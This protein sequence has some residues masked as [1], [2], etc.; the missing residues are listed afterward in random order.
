MSKQAASRRR[1]SPA[2]AALA[3]VA[4][5]AGTLAGCTPSVGKATPPPTVAPSPNTETA[6]E[7]FE[8]YY[9]QEVVF[10]PCQADQVT[11]ELV[12]PPKDIENYQCAVLEAPLD[13]DDPQSESIELAVAVYGSGD[14]ALFYNL[15]GP[16]GDAIES[17]STFVGQLVPAAVL[18]AYQVVALDPRGVGESTPVR[19]WDDATRDQMNAGFIGDEQ[20]PGADGDASPEEI[21]AAY[22][23]ESATTAQACLE[24]SGEIV[25]YV[26]T[27]SAARDFDM[28]RA[29]LGHQK[30]N[31]LGYS[32]GTALGA[33][34]AD[35]FPDRVG[36][37][38][39]DGALDPAVNANTL[40]ALQAAG[41][42]EAL[43]HWIEDC[44]GSSG[45]PLSGDME[46]AHQ[47]LNDFFADLAEAP[48]AT[49]QPGRELTETLARTGVVGS[50][51][52]PQTYSLL[53][54]ALQLAMQAGDGATLLFLADYYNGRNEDGTYSGQT[55]AFTAINS[56]DMLPVGT[57]EE[58]IAQADQLATDHPVLGSQ[59]GFA[60]AT[61][62]GWPFAA[63]RPR[64]PVTAAGSP[65]ILIIGTLHDPATPYV[66]AQSLADA[67]EN[68]VLVTYDGW[69]HG[70]Y[71]DGGNACIV[72]TVDQFLIDGTV[73][74]DG[75]TCDD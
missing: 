46:T 3:A 36:R 24:K 61:L 22:R 19:C 58:W 39:L 66:M 25:K 73:P 7:G 10:S 68:G 47:Q 31:F 44:L 5:F 49:D 65:E 33:V 45:C 27:D 48:L 6:P 71:R 37:M 52:S 38:V 17:L 15:G 63:A 23:Q 75:V 29:A 72:E 2:G 64:G 8:R 34:Y 26:D 16:G 53:T 13:W 30:L 9:Q 67:L 11:A 69:G 32:Y 42:Q 14:E 21:I 55:D 56:L 40:T 18:D 41:M 35:L 43:D 57:E 70:A 51:Y 62:E 4:V 12:S 59:F 28:A 1:T 54:M 20:V 74:E 60:S 50:L